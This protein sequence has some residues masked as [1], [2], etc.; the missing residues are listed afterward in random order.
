[1]RRL[2]Y[3]RNG[4]RGEGGGRKGCR[5]LRTADWKVIGS[6]ID[7]FMADR[8]GEQQIMIG[9]KYAYLQEVFV[10][11]NIRPDFAQAMG[12]IDAFCVACDLS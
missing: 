11:T 9:G 8:Y 12:H 2:G 6:L 1:M 10:V 7:V 4:K 3:C 5:S